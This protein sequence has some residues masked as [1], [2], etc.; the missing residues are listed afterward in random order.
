M[1]PA[2]GASTRVLFLRAGVHRCRPDVERAR[3]ATSRPC[4]GD[5]VRRSREHG[6][7]TG[8]FNPRRKAWLAPSRW[9]PRSH[10]GAVDLR[11]L[12]DCQHSCRDPART[13]PQ[14]R[15]CAANGRNE[16]TTRTVSALLTVPVRSAAA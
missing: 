4:D 6:L 8:D 7:S 2:D 13:R 5:R 12:E 15:R 10:P 14:S 3:G 16:V 9:R 11:L 1:G